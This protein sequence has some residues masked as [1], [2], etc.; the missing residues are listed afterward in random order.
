MRRF[1][2]LV[3]IFLISTAI[4]AT[5][6]I[7]INITPSSSPT[8]TQ[9]NH[10]SIAPTPALPPS[11][12]SSS[13][14]TATRSPATLTST[15]APASKTTPTPTPAATHTSRSS[16]ITAPISGIDLDVTYINR[17][18]RYDWKA[19]KKWPSDGEPVTFT[20]HI[21]NNGST[22]SGPFAFQWLIDNEEVTNGVADSIPSQQESTQTLSWKWKNGRHRVS[23]QTDPKNQISDVARNNNSVTDAT[24][25]LTLAFW[26]EQSVYNQY[27]SNKNVGGTYSWEDWA[28]STI[29]RMNRMFEQSVYPLA[30]Q[31]VRTRVRLDNIAVVPD[32]T[33]FKQ[34]PWHAPSDTIYDGRWGFS[35][36]EYLNPPKN[37]YDVPQWVIHELGHYLFVIFDLYAL[38]RTGWRHQS[39]R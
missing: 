32:G 11:P 9:T 38:G 4:M 10:P 14:P 16:Q 5:S 28:Q 31:G 35:I 23:F 12:S 24:D 30:P 3:A 34:G 18:P 22:P 29:Q 2:C 7:T 8:P 36:E 21:V 17:E 13:S 20:A 33:L 1:C 27:N 15:P 39:S 6:C 25:A 26:V 37:Y 19:T